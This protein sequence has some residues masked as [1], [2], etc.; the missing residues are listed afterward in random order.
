MFKIL[1]TDLVSI[2]F[3]ALVVGG[4]GKFD[5]ELYSPEGKCQHVLAKVPGRMTEFWRP[6]LAYLGGKI[7]ACHGSENNV[8]CWEY[9]TSKNTWSVLTN[10]KTNHNHFP[11]KSHFSRYVKQHLNKYIKHTLTPKQSE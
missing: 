9:E 8:Y 5:V 10:S 2:G 3:V 6:V 11:G 7:M 4:E 1:I